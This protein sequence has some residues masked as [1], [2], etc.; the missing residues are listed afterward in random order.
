MQFDTW[1]ASEH[2]YGQYEIGLRCL[3]L[4]ECFSSIL[5]ARG[6]IQHQYLVRLGEEMVQFCRMALVIHGL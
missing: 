5:F 2:I 4:L 1:G 3:T 6:L